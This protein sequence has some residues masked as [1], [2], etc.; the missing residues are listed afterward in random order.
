MMC[1]QRSY[2]IEQRAQKTSVT[3][4][5]VQCVWLSVEIENEQKQMFMIFAHR[6]DQTEQRAQK[7]SATHHQLQYAWVSVEIEIKAK[8]R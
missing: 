3:H 8:F 6:Q 4:E 2:Q 7:S 1:T 5:Q